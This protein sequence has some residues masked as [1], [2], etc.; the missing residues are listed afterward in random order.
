MTIQLEVCI[1]NLESLRYAQQ[2]GA[3]RIE[4]CSSL[5]LGGLTPSVGFM[6]AAAK[7]ATVPVYA[8]IRPRQGDF[9]FSSEDVEIMLADIYA[10]KQA[11]L[12]GVVIGVLTS[13]GLVD[14]D[15]VTRLVKQ[16][17]GMGVTFHR[18]IDQCVEPIAA[19]DTIM[20]AGCERILTSGLQAN[21]YDG[22][23]MI[24]QMHQY[25]GQRLKIMAGAGVNSHNVREIIARTGI[26]EIHLSGKTTRPSQMIT[27]TKQAHMGNADIDDFEIPITGAAN[28]AAVIAQLQQ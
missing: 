11:G 25:C 14:S 23:G 3:T 15:I 24:N 16:A 6:H 10:A 21:A 12:Q 8:M 1:D 2:G 27:V 22:I 19:L 4:L 18:A 13:H 20:A 17:Q 28:I 26:N 9:L 5:A 7:Y